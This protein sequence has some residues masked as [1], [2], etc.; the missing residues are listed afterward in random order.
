MAGLLEIGKLNRGEIEPV[1][2]LPA[3]L[4]YAAPALAG[5]VVVWDGNSGFNNFVVKSP[6]RRIRNCK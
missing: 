4:S 1:T 2:N 5:L 3:K 6:P